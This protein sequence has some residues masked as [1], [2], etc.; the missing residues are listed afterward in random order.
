MSENCQQNQKLT[1][2]KSKKTIKDQLEKPKKQISTNGDAVKKLEKNQ[3]AILEKINSICASIKKLKDGLKSA[4][5]D[6]QLN[7]TNEV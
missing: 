3:T 6:N 5:I 4:P 7:V 2:A 1:E